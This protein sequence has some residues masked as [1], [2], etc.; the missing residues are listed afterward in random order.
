MSTAEGGLESGRRLGEWV[1]EAPLGKGG[2]AEVWRA[3]HNSLEGKK[4]A[5]K[6]PFD[7]DYAAR[8]ENAFLVAVNCHE[9]GGTCFCVS[10]DTGP[11]A[12]SGYD[13]LLTEL[14]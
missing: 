14:L 10:M 2:F 5:V 12:R 3:H 9:P 4:A 6:V 7:R 13:V 8:R 11:T 1:L